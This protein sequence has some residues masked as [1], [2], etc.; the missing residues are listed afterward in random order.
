MLVVA[1]LALFAISLAP[2]VLAGSAPVS[3]KPPTQ[4]TDGTVLTD[5]SGFRFYYGKS[6]DALTT[7]VT[8]A[9]PS[10]CSTTIDNLAPGTWY[11]TVTALTSAGAESENAN[12]VSTVVADAT[13][14]CPAAPANETRAQV[15]TAPLVGSWT[16]THGWTAAAS[17]TCWT[18]NAWAPAAAPAG[19]CAQPVLLTAGP[20]SYELTGTAA[21]PSMSAIGLVPAGLQCSAT[22]KTVGGVQFCQIP[23][24][25]SDLIGWP[26]DKTLAAG[27]W[28][29]V[30]P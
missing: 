16:Q 27:V 1:V 5:L 4:N 11:F 8:L 25:Q 26:V 19:A 18:A 17:P 7:F 6:V 15:C 10:P 3:C 20:Y 21:K 22:L 24:S 30:A 23:R 12:P 29:R 2:P 14:T 13:P 9:K 28:A